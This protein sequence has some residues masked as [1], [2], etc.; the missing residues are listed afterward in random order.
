MKTNDLQDLSIYIHIPFCVRKCLYCDFLSAPPRGDQIERYVKALLYEIESEAPFYSGYFVRTVFFGGGTPSLLSGE[1]IGAIMDV[2]NNCFHM[3]SHGEITMECN[4][5]TAT[6][7]HLHDYKQTGVNRLS[8]G[9]QSANDKEL[10]ELGRIHTWGDFKKTYEDALTAGFS[11]INVDLMSA[12]PG[13]SLQSYENTLNHVIA[14]QPQHISAYSLIIEEGTPFYDRYST[15]HRLCIEQEQGIAKTAATLAGKLSYPPPSGENLPSEEEERQMYR[16]T[17]KIMLKSGY[18]RYEIS[19][20]SKT[21]YECRHNITY[22]TGGDYAGFG[23]GAASYVAGVRYKNTSQLSKYLERMEKKDS[24]KVLREEESILEPRDKMEE[25]M[26]MGLRLMKG[27]SRAKF[28]NEFGCNME[29]I[30]GDVLKQ[31]HEQRL[32]VFHG[33]RIC[34]TKRGIDISNYVMAEFLL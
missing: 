23:I 27:I 24:P 13:Q 3:D 22:W 15:D 16:Q 31:L 32:L 8:I 2:L 21:G 11:N 25:Y 20:Y 26:F 28:G 14:L 9:L 4:P 19:N 7:E 10:R 30:Y 12:L 29:T 33:D 34:L 5:G 1:Q 18:H 6:Y 17:E